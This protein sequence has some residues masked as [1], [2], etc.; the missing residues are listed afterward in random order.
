MN[1]QG[2]PWEVAGQAEDSVV[3]IG[4]TCFRRAPFHPK[5]SIS[6]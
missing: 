1:D 5:K 4:W 2:Q 6:D 3:S